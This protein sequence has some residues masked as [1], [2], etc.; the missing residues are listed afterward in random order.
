MVRKRSIALI[1][2]GCTLIFIALLGALFPFVP[3]L[4]SDAKQLSEY[5]EDA[6]DLLAKDAIL[7]EIAPGATGSDSTVP[8]PTP[9]PRS[10]PAD[11]NRLFIE[12]IGVSVPI[13]EGKDAGALLYGAW[14]Y[15]GTST[16]K[17]GS[18]T[19]VFGHRFRYLPPNNTTFYSLDKLKL[20]DTLSARW[21]GKVYT[22]KVAQTKIIE[23]NDFSVVAPSEKSIITLITCSPLFSTK[24]RLVVVAEQIIE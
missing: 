9:T 22:Y 20:G 11:D 7:E 16:P 18:N 19:V 2:A 5:V 8:A 14:R 10:K 4:F 6:D 3:I 12:K 17:K 15:P 13:V 21:Q 24:Q 23:P 1:G